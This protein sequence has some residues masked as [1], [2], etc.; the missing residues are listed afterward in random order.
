MSNKKSYNATEIEQNLIRQLGENG[1]IQMLDESLP[2][3]SGSSHN[4]IRQT[5][6]L[7]M[8]EVDLENE[9]APAAVPPA[10]GVFNTDDTC[11]LDDHRANKHGKCY[12][13]TV[14]PVL[15]FIVAVV[16]VSSIMA[17]VI[18]S[19]ENKKNTVARP[20]WIEDAKMVE[21]QLA[22]KNPSN[23]I[24]PS[25]NEVQDSAVV[26]VQDDNGEDDN[27]EVQ[28][29]TEDND[30]PDFD[31]EDEM[32]C[33]PIIKFKQELF[34]ESV[35]QVA[36]D[37]HTIVVKHGKRLNFYEKDHTQS[38]SPVS[39]PQTHSKSVESPFLTLALDGA[40]SLFGDYLR[41]HETGA[42]YIVE[43]NASKNQTTRVVPV[44]APDD[45]DEGGMFGFSIDLFKDRLIV[46]AP[47]GH[48]ENSG[49]AYVYERTDEGD[50]EL[51]WIFPPDE[52]DGPQ[53]EFRW[54]GD[55]VA[56]HQDRA[57]VAG[58]NEFKEV[59]VFIYEYSS[60][61]DSWEEIDDII[62]DKKCQGCK[63]VG[64][65]VSFREDGG[66]FISYPRKN[67]VSYMVPTSFDNGGE[68]VL[69]QKIP[70]DE[71]YDV[72]MDQVE[73]GGDI[74]V[75][76][77][78]DEFDTN[79]VFVYSQSDDDDRWVKVD[80]I[81]LP[82]NENFDPDKDFVDLALSRTNLI[83]NYGDDNLILYTLDGCDA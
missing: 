13:N 29:E 81:E 55:S 60:I 6:S 72:D 31:D 62:V 80:E 1:S 65:A 33:V 52:D 18:V 45:V 17:G 43:Q 4:N 54:F 12:R 14:G 75:V 11:D 37:G 3:M 38:A 27:K 36:S 22:V 19:V 16:V 82:P 50:W 49:S 61:S 47:F 63:E 59:T 76:G 70:V 44:L 56:M 71:D 79:L 28:G 64:V 58:F 9:Y 7:Y 30:D 66:L 73:I 74:M 2:P 69:V 68:Y 20:N 48:G 51:E 41:D 15:L 23:V 34:P 35:P 46:G 40:T 53:D 25:E 78:T 32:V 24:D 8:D 26:V 42:V 39:L 10:R 67:T 57:A 21:T 77:V 5:S 83:V